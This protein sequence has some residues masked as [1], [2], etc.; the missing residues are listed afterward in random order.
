MT[1]FGTELARLMTARGLG[2]RELARELERQRR[3]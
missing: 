3:C 1:E 2:V